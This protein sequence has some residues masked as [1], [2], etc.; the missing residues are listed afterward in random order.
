MIYDVQNP[1]TNVMLNKLNMNFDQNECYQMFD[2]PA[3]KQIS[4]DSI[5]QDYSSKLNGKPACKVEM[6]IKPS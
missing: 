2:K 3:S 5:V 4:L 6:L 1:V